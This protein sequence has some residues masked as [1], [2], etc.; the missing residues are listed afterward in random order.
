VIL[1]EFSPLRNIDNFYFCVNFVLETNRKDFMSRFQTLLDT[2]YPIGGNIHGLE[3]VGTELIVDTQ[4]AGVANVNIKG[5]GNYTLALEPGGAG[6]L[7]LTAD[8]KVALVRQVRIP[9]R[10]HH[11]ELPCG[12]KDKNETSRDTAIREAR[13]E[14]GMVVKREYIRPLPFLIFTAPQRTTDSAQIYFAR[15]E[16]ESGQADRGPEITD[17]KFFSIPEIKHMIHT[18]SITHAVT[19]ASL[20]WLMAEE[21]R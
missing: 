2:S 14:F 7:L 10:T 3:I 5:M 21:L 12:N 1:R 9:S 6:I 8:N 15:A 4:F 18:G 20:Y 13:E 11:W 19:L 17:R 16:Y